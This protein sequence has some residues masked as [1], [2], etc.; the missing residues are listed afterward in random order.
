M[1]PRLRLTASA[2][3]S[4]RMRRSAASSQVGSLRS[5]KPCRWLAFL[6]IESGWSWSPSPAKYW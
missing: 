4:S 6:K 5:Q 3:I 2:V 1:K